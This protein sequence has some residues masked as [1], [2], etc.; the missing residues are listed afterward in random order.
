MIY[1]QH[2][3]VALQVRDSIS[4]SAIVKTIHIRWTNVL[5]FR[6]TPWAKSRAQRSQKQLA[7]MHK[8]EASRQSSLRAAIS[9]LRRLLENLILPVPELSKLALG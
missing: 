8:R 9:A 3:R 1:I 4:Y 7:Q 5:P 2:K 6:A